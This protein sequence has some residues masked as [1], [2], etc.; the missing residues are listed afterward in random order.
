MLFAGFDVFQHHQTLP[1]IIVAGVIGD[2]AGASIAYAIGYFA[3]Q[4]LLQHQGKLH[5][6]AGSIERAHRWFDRYG[7]PVMFITR[8]LPF[9][10]AAF[11][12][13]AGVARMSYWR[14][15]TAATLGSIIWIGGLGLLG[16][17]VGSQWQTWRHHLEYVD[18]V[19]V[20]VVV[21]AI[22]YLI[23]RRM[24]GRPPEPGA[25][26]PPREWAGP[27]LRSMPS[28][29]DP[30]RVARAPS[31][32][33]ALALGA[34]HGPAELLP[35][36]SSGH[37]ALIPWL[38]GWER[39]AADPELRKAFEVALHAGTAAALL[40][41]LRGEVKDAMRGMNLRA[42]GQI[43]LSFA[44]PRSPA[45]PWSARSSSGSALRRRSPPASC[46]VRWRWSGP[47]AHRSCGASHDADWRDALW[48]GVAQAC[49]LVP[50]VSRNG[51]TL[52]A[53]RRRGFTR[54]DAN[55][56]SRHVALPVIA[57]AT[58]LKSVRLA[59][60]GHAAR[61]GPPVRRRG[62]RVRSFPRWAPH[63]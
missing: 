27:V 33:R 23:A 3:S 49:A 53:A 52:A 24:R 42:A 55:R 54:A 41:T 39:D 62:G 4:E 22:V 8:L 7:T 13:A 45:T 58:L 1:G 15:M 44:P 38:L 59:K 48:L 6:R 19:G 31:L 10:R 40:I 37:I 50:G 14:C 60:R 12:Y 9:V 32:R 2:I 28:A 11:P 17:E 18:Y 35:I 20:I 5:I 47:T 63:G 21:A 61:D 56:L 16:R 30:P 46:A 26:E 43:A 51:A 25:G 29:T 57:G 34:L 36:S